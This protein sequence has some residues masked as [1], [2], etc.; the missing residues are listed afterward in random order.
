MCRHDALSVESFDNKSHC[1]LVWLSRLS[2]GTAHNQLPSVGAFSSQRESG[3]S[4]VAFDIKSWTL[5]QIDK[6]H[7]LH[8]TFS[9]DSPIGSHRYKAIR[10]DA[11]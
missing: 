11:R 9:H 4:A 10:T 8:C 2:R 3:R 6:G 5:T 1:V 7:K